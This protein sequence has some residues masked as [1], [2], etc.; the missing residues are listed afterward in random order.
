MTTSVSLHTTSS[1]LTAG[2]LRHKIL[3]EKQDLVQSH[4][5]KLEA[6]KNAHDKLV[7]Q[8]VDFIYDQAKIALEKNPF[9]KSFRLFNPLDRPEIDGFK[10]LYLLYGSYNKTSRTY[11]R[12]FHENAGIHFTPIEETNRILFNKGFSVEDISDRNKSINT[13]L[14]IRMLD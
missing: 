2:E 7:E 10:W 4:Q 12:S 13:V 14:L 6:I 3:E 5:Q 1:L 8:L 9:K 11:N